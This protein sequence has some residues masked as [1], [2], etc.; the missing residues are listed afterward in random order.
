MTWK[1]KKKVKK[2]NLYIQ[3]PIN[4]MIKKIDNYFYY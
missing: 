4:L 1:K 3:T 2:M